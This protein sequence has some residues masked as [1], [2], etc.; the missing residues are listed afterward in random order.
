MPRPIRDSS[1]KLHTAKPYDRPAATSSSEKKP[2]PL[3]AGFAPTETGKYQ[4]KE[5]DKVVFARTEPGRPATPP[6]GAEKSGQSSYTSGTA[7]YDKFEYK[8]KRVPDCLF[9]TEELMN[10]KQYDPRGKGTINSKV[11]VTGEDFGVSNKANIQAS[12]KAKK[13]DAAQVNEHVNP[14]VGDGVA[15]VR[16]GKP[17]VGESPYHAAPVVAR[18]GNQFLTAE[19]SAPASGNAVKERTTIPK[20]HAFTVGDANNSFHGQLATADQ[21]GEDA[22]TIGLK[23]KDP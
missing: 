11:A 19:V 3:P 21:Y 16:Q 2:R 4:T 9:T 18:D 15:I 13:T 8:Q 22:I 12:K 17:G 6:L 7:Q 1:P 23:K 5:G 14:Q 10:D 20:V